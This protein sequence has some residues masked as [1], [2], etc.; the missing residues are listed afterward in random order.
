MV[1]SSLGLGLGLGNK[2]DGECL[3]EVNETNRLFKVK[4]YEN[5]ANLR[6]DSS[7]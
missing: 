3:E 7:P 1:C 2:E 5:K 4:T 6:A